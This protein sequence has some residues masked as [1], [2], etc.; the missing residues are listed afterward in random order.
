MTE[1]NKKYK[2]LAIIGNGFDLAH[3]Y[4][5][6]FFDFVEKTT[7]T[8]LDLFREF[9]T[10]NNIITWHNFEENIKLITINFWHDNFANGCDCDEISG[11]IEKLNHVFTNIHNLLLNY[12][13]IELSRFESQKKRKVAK[14]LNLKTKVVTFNYTNLAE[15]YTKDIFHVHGSV[16][17]GKMILGYDYRAEPCLISMEYMYWYKNFRRELLAFQRYLEHEQGLKDSEPNY[18]ILVENFEKYQ[19]C[20]NSGRGIDEDAR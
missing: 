17:E 1:G 12:L 7:D 3:G 19:I 9:C 16:D 13:K 18:K 20:A 15:I 8:D 11:K 5:T 10:N 4:R 14:Y 2:S 6:T